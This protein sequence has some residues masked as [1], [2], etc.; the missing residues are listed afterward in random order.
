MTKDILIQ[1]L[2]HVVF[3]CV[4][5]VFMA[6]ITLGIWNTIGITSGISFWQ[7]LGITVIIRI[8]TSKSSLNFKE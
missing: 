6:F 2:I 4:V 5:A 3:Q 1:K 7:A 8:L